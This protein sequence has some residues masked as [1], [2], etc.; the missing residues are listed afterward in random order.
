M[1]EAIILAGGFGTRLQ[2]VVSDVPK[3]MA[4]VAGRPFLAWQLDYLIQQNVSRFILSVG[5]KAEKI[6]E[7]FG[8]QYKNAEIVYAQESSPLGTGGA[9]R[10]AL[11]QV[12][13]NRVFVLN[14]DSL[15]EVNL[16][17]LRS[18]LKDVSDIGIFVKS[19]E[20][21]GRYGAIQFDEGT[22]LVT[23]FGEK[24]S[25]DAGYINVGVYDIPKDIFNDDVIDSPFSFEA[26]VLQNAVNKNLFAQKSGEF[27]I[28]IG[29]PE[30]FDRAQS[31]IPEKFE[32]S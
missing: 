3:P 23:R 22:H 7:Y 21:A 18:S 12:I 29:I 20:N 16:M 26:Q 32:L 19:V 24:S 27:F 2:S 1:Y 8:F 15:C 28:D 5:Y 11:S 9:I 25:T 6:R 13:Q 30:D 10:F 31:A 14:G 17:Q 4:P